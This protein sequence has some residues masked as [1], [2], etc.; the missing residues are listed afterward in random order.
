M[1][2][3]GGS[4]EGLGRVRS[5]FDLVPIWWDLGWIWVGS[6]LDLGWIWVGS[7]GSPHQSMESSSLATSEALPSPCRCARSSLTKPVNQGEAL[8]AALYCPGGGPSAQLAWLGLGVGGQ[9]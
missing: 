4:G 2:R 8:M 9:G 1:V 3:A 7:G 5:G 6:G